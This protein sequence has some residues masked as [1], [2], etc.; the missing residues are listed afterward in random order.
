MG[1]QCAG[2]CRSGMIAQVHAA[3]AVPRGCRAAR[4][5]SAM[6]GA[7]SDTAG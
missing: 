2:R 3:T 1:K 6:S 7:E 5:W 4:G